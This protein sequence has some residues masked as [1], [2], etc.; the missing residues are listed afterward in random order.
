MNDGVTQIPVVREPSPLLT[1]GPNSNNLAAAAQAPHPV[2]AL[3]SAKSMQL[4]GG[5][6]NNY[7]HSVG[8]APDLDFARHVYGSGLAMQLATERRFVATGAGCI[9]PI[10]DDDGGILHHGLSVTGLP[11]QTHVA[12][13]TRDVLIG[14]DTTLD[15]DDVLG[16][17]QNNPHLGMGPNGY[18]TNP[19][20][21]ME[22]QLH[23]K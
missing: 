17:P 1:T 12:S 21:V 10:L 8:G 20:V 23:M 19:H 22:H 4:S 3:Q 9:A 2:A 16:L 7:G 15:F 13:I 11:L 18:T 14:H 5:Y 6:R